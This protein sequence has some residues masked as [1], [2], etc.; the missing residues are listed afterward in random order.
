MKLTTAKIYQL[1]KTLDVKMS[2]KN[3]AATTKS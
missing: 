3:K 2:E 1:E